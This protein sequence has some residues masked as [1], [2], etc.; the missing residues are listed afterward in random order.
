MSGYYLAARQ[1]E[2]FRGRRNSGPN[3]DS[4][5]DALAIA[6]HH[7]AVTGTEK[8]HVANDYSK[9]LSIGYKKAE[10]LVSSS[11]AWLIESPLLTTCQ[12]TCPLLN[13]NCCPAS[14]VD[15][16]QGKNLFTTL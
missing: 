11:L 9:Q 15:L 5:A 1:L 3:T 8:Q 12:N 13:I 4:L 7:D 6:Q 2:F 16:V 10:D 14:E